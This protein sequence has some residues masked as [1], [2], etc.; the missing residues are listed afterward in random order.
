M[1]CGE[2][3]M[4]LGVDQCERSYVDE[5]SKNIIF[6]QDILKVMALTLSEMILI[7]WKF[8]DVDLFIFCVK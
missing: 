5:S 2:R 7:N 1:L 4:S 6:G 8:V 3:V